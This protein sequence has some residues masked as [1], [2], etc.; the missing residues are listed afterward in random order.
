MISDGEGE[1]MNRGLDSKSLSIY[2]GFGG[3]HS[4][5]SASAGKEERVEEEQWMLTEMQEIEHLLNM[6]EEEQ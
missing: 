4:L 5:F 1:F 6:V 3:M 2:E